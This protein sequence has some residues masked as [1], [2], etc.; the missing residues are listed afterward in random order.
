MH[1]APTDR[2]D[3]NTVTATA[4]IA[5]ILV[6]WFL[7]MPR[8]EPPA[9]PPNTDSTLVVDPAPA[10][11]ATPTPVATDTT[12]GAATRGT[13]RAI[14]VETERY[15][16]VLSTEGASFRSF[17]LKDFQQADRRTP[18]E[19]IDTA[20]AKGP[21]GLVFTTPRS[22]TVDT[23]ALFFETPAEGTVRVTGDSL[24]VP[25]E[26]Q[27]GGGRLRFQ[28]VFY[29]DNYTV[30]WNV[31]RDSSASFATAEGYDVVWS[32]A[33]PFSEEPTERR[34]ELLRSGA[35]ARSGGEVEG[36][37]LH[38]DAEATRTL[39]GQVEWVAVKNKY[40]TAALFPQRPTRGATL[41]GLRDG[42]ADA[43]NVTQDY[44]VRLDMATLPD[45]QVDR[46]R[47]YVGPMDYFRLRRLGGD[48][49]D[50]VD[51]GWDWMEVATR[52][53]A[54]LVFIPFF[55][56]FGS[57]LPGYGWVLI[58]F[59][60]AIKLVTYPLTRA[61]SRSMLR[62]RAIGPKMQLIK[63]RYGSDP[64]RQQQEMMKLYK[65]AGVNP[66]GGC[67]PL[68]LQY[69]VLIALYQFIPQ[70][71]DLRQEPFLWA[72]DLSAPDPILHLP[73][74]IPLY[75]DFVAGFT[76]LM[77][78][79]LVVQMRLQNR[80]QPAATPEQEVQMKIMQW[81]IPLMLFVF[82]NRAAAGLSLY[83]LFYN[84]VSALE[85]WYIRK[86]TPELNLDD[87]DNAPAAPVAPRSTPP[88]RKL[89]AL[90]Q[91]AAATNGQRGR[92]RK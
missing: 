76:L 64:Q 59:A 19:L 87:E 15:T 83:Y 49:Y 4:L 73:F 89:E 82:F 46:Y 17:R 45:G 55:S 38:G 6:G 5:L 50:M 61:Q 31:V 51:F 68:L 57:F 54:K 92:K 23:R 36:V 1:R 27:V 9:P 72:R 41:E 7:L 69:P 28:Y 42:A 24:V 65:R 74:N 66:L 48:L 39:S 12:L 80:N 34:E 84:V 52:P 25:F 79:S 30:G 43:L 47:L 78:L 77:G 22:R 14:T 71:M 60:I 85:Q 63:E 2:M 29:R 40:F 53:I 18:V 88:K 86:S 33:V 8:P 32:G 67:L 35:Y 37:T 16:A 44:S 26:A 75:G 81:M 56:F 3:R 13:A 90:E 58:V 91:A 70:S 11:D 10:P 62:M 21:L 20:Q